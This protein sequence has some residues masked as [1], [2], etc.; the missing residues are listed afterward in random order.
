MYT[1]HNVASCF[2]ADGKAPGGNIANQCSYQ[3]YCAYHS[4]FGT[5]AS[6]EYIYANMPWPNQAFNFGGQIYTTDCDAGEHPNGTGSESN[7]TDP[8]GPTAAD[9]ADEVINV[10]SHENNESITDPTGYGWW[11][12]N[13]LSPYVGYEDGD[14]CAWYWASDNSDYAGQSGN[15][16]FYTNTINGDQYFLQGEWSNADANGNGESGCQWGYTITQPTPSGS[17]SLTGTTSVGQTLT[18]DAGNWTNAAVLTYTWEHC[19]DN[20]GD[21]CVPFMTDVTNSTND[22]YVLQPSDAGTYIQVNVSGVDGSTPAYAGGSS[23]G[24]VGSLGP[25]TGEPE[26]TVSPTIT[27]S[28]TDL[29]PGTVL[30]GHVGTW[31]P[32]PTGYTVMWQ[33]CTD[34]LDP[35]T[36]VTF[37]TISLKSTTTTSTYTLTNADVRDAIS[38]LVVARNAMG[39]SQ[40]QPALTAAVGGYPTLTG[41]DPTVPDSPMVGT[42]ATI[43]LGGWSGPTG[44]AI[45]GYTVQIERCTDPNDLTTCELS[46]TLSATATKTSVSYTPVAADDKQYLVALVSAKD[47]YGV[48]DTDQGSSLN[49]VGGEPVVI[50]DPTVTTGPVSVGDDI[51]LNFGTWSNN[52]TQFRVTLFRCTS[53]TDESTCTNLAIA[54]TAL[55]NPPPN[56]G[57]YTAQAGDSGDYIRIFVQAI[58][59][60]GFS[61]GVWSGACQ[62]S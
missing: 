58:N 1:P 12:D 39:S 46:T 27:Q 41:A 13:P 54:R 11:V 17:P 15:G 37:K 38:F 9:A 18:A 36:C 7:G 19:S 57:D 55:G 44:V 42:P 61:D 33:R 60:V 5:T 16:S 59:A 24:T 29:F 21:N 10:S 31:S 48:S 40:P 8:N 4:E 52:P 3:Y 47:K 28:K 6:T 25:I 56:T 2:Y 34:P 35:S 26:N 43:T 23:P 20:S 49:P 30:T 22:Q 14:L 53:A 45:S 51:S 62:V 50:S 32:A